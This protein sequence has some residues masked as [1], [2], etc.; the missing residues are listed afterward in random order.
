MKKIILITTFIALISV[1]VFSSLR[2]NQENVIFEVKKSDFITSITATGR[3]LP[4]EEIDLAFSISDRI[5]QVNAIVGDRVS[6][7]QVLATLNDAEIRSQIV[8]LEQNLASQQARLNNINA[9]ENLNKL[10][11]QRNQLL[12]SINRSFVIADDVIRNRVDLFFE[13][14]QA[15]FS[16]FNNSLVDFF[17]RRRIEEKRHSIRFLLEDWQ[18]YNH[19]IESDLVSIQDANHAINNLKEI[20]KILDLITEGTTRFEPTANTTQN[21]I[22]SYIIGI[23][24][25]RN[26]ISNTILELERSIESLQNVKNEIPILEANVSGAMAAIDTLKARLDKYSLIAPLSGTITK[27][28]I[29]TGQTSNPNST[30]FSIIS[31]AGLEIEIFIPEILVAGVQEQNEGFATFDA[32][33]R[34]NRFP[35][36]V[37]KIEPRETIKDGVTTYKTILNFIENVLGLRPGM[38][39]EVTIYKEKIENVLVIPNHLIETINGE[40][41]VKILESDSSNI[42]DRKIEVGPSDGRGQSLILSGL[43]E[44]DKIII[45]SR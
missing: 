24:N 31:D 23:S 7:G 33:G 3:V 44:G 41:F 2:R 14:P 22:D 18:K 30:A 10:R 25:S 40:N 15:R 9:D 28:N 38:T 13:N 29:Q 43:N 21:Q 32:L 17:L 8:E 11:I 34:E 19:N 27:R 39:T 20:S 42:I 37:S 16:N 35:V 26:T 36:F 1:I 5:T 45:S 6:V 4:S 12:S